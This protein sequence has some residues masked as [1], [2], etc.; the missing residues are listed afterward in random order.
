MHLPCCCFVMTG[1]AVSH[2]SEHAYTCNDGRANIRAS[3]CISDT[4]KPTYTAPDITW[5]LQYLAVC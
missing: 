1:I 2:C 5:N 4:V 3:V